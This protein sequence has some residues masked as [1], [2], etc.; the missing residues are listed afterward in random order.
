MR[1]SIIIIIILCF[2]HSFYAQNHEVDYNKFIN[3]TQKSI[4]D[5]DKLLF[6]WWI[7]SDFW[8]ISLERNNMPQEQIDE[9]L[10]VVDPYVMFIMADGVIGSLGGITYSNYEEINSNCELIDSDGNRYTPIKQESISP[11]MKNLLL[12]MKPLFKNLIGAMGENMQFII[13]DTV[14][15]KFSNTSEKI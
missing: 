8:T 2:A 5:P 1:I 13:F 9:F 6:A 10:T 7:P 15:K 14:K 12:M 11:D 3:E 4:S